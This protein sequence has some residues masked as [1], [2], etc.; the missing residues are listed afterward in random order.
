MSDKNKEKTQFVKVLE[1][2]GNS[3]E[4]IHLL[5]DAM[6]EGF[7]L[8]EIICDMKGKP[9]DYRFLALNPAFEVLTGLKEAEIIGKKVR[10]VLPKLEQYWIDTYGKVAL[11]GETV[12]FENYSRELDRYYDVIA[13]SPQKGYFATLFI[14]ITNRKLAEKKIERLYSLQETIRKINQFILRAKREDE[15]LQRVCNI[16]TKIGY[17]KFAWIGLIERGSFDVKLVAQAGFE[18]GYLSS[19]KVT[20]DDSEYG[21]GPT[22][23]TIKMRKPFIIGDIESDPKYK[24]WREEALR[25]GYKSSMAMPLMDRGDVVGALNVY[26]ELKDAFGDEEVGF[27]MEVAGDIA[28]GIKSLRLEKALEQSYEDIKKVLDETVKAISLIGEMRDPYT[29]GHQQRVSQLACAIAK[30]RR[31]SARQREGIRIAGLLH[32]VGKIAVP[33]EILTKPG[34]LNDYE[35]G[36][37]RTHPQVGHKALNAINFP[38][39]VAQIVLQHHE[40]IDGSGYP[41]GIS[42]E[43]IIPEARILAVADVVEAMVSHRPYRPAFSISKALEEISKNKGVLYDPGAVDACLLLFRERGFKFA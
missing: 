38:W 21:Q 33:A 1:P 34:A 11:T 13:F 22:G 17:V 26:S 35:L 37:I 29:A 24:P 32:D 31:F 9:C 4:A 8:H 15:L 12:R 42:G 16:L 30:E 28:V 20:W 18:V 43:E 25:R 14:D 7:A 39:P 10:E 5:F 19:I 6:H 36:I 41:L 40:R 23:M 2:L 27:F 3:E